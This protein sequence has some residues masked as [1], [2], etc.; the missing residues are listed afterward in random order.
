MKT[1]LT[2]RIILLLF[3]VEKSIH[4]YW[5]LWQYDDLTDSNEF[6]P[7][8]IHYR[9]VFDVIIIYSI[10]SRKQC[11]IHSELQLQISRN[12]TEKWRKIKT[13]WPFESEAWTRPGYLGK[14][15]DIVRFWE[16]FNW[17][18]FCVGLDLNTP[19][20]NEYL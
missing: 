7:I 20:S 11:F 17:T 3:I 16:M 5:S 4:F 19:L 10:F 6:D 14:S 1:T 2:F 18:F 15:Y 13:F 9:W 8:N 12:M